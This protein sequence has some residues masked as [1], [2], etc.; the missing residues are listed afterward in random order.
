MCR[1]EGDYRVKAGGYRGE[2]ENAGPWGIAEQSQPIGVP[3]R[4][5]GRR[6]NDRRFHA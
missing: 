2:A 5:Q 1:H 6:R 4:C 3:V